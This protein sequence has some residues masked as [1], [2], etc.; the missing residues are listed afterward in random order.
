M[1]IKLKL[2]FKILFRCEQNLS[3]ESK[4]FPMYPTEETTFG[5]SRNENVPLGP[6][7]EILPF[8]QRAGERKQGKREHTGYEI[9]V[10]K[11]FFFAVSTAVSTAL[12]GDR[13]LP[14]F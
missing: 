11:E 3:E 10:S 9:A 6:W 12:R 2:Y 13:D 4:M 1:T 7:R 8:G 5:L 14:V